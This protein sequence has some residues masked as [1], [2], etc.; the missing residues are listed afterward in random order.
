MATPVHRMPFGF[1]PS[2]GPRQGPDGAPHDWH[3]RPLRRVVTVDYLTEPAPLAALLPPG[4]TLAGEPV[5]SVEVQ[6]LSELSWLAGRGYNIIGVRFPARFCGRQDDVTGLFVAVMWENLADPILTGRDELGFAKLWAEIPPPRIFG[7]REVH[8]A[9]WL[10][11]RFVDITLTDITPIEAFPVAT[12][13]AAGGLL[14]YKYVP[15]TG[16]PGEADIARACHTPPGPASLRL[17]AATACGEVRFHETTWEDM[18]TQFHIIQRLAALPVLEA[19]GARV[20]VTRGGR[21]LSD[22]RQLE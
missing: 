8:G 21:D 20:A 6:Y 9:S 5:V 13:P 2:P 19:R 1:G 10:G 22:Q 11:H 12:G 14:H 3:D 7:D 18:P 4:F 16:R 15:A 17:S